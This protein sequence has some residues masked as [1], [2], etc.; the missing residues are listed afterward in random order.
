M[1][2]ADIA[3]ALEQLARLLELLGEDAFRVNAHARAARAVE[4]SA[5]ELAALA[6]LAPAS[7]AKAA[8]TAIEGIGP[9]LAEKIIELVTTGRLAD[10]DEAA[11]KVPPGLLPLLQL[12]GLGPKTVR[13]F[14][15]DA[16]VTDLAG[17]QGII[18]DGRILSL[19]RM[20]AKAVEKLKAAIAIADQAGTRLALG[21][22]TVVAER[23]MAN[24]RRVAGVQRLEA[25]G[26]LR[27]G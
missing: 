6:R 21:R 24:L 5:E 13:M 14:W 20:G 18:A 16:G 7:K 4:G 27:R 12:Q 10:L 23:V 3:A 25:A 17:L 8:L 9:K 26:S 22:A 15:Q 2:N 11:A 1:T 19:P